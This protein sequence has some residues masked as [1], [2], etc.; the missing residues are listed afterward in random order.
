MQKMK[1]HNNSTKK[2]TYRLDFCNKLYM[3]TSKES[4][5]VSHYGMLHHFY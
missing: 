5:N 4:T 1:F 2:I 3:F